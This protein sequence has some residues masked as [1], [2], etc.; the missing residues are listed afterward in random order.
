MFIPISSPGFFHFMSTYYDGTID[1]Q[2]QIQIMPIVFYPLMYKPD[3][4]FSLMEN[5][6]NMFRVTNEGF[7]VH[8]DVMTNFTLA[9]FASETF[10]KLTIRASWEQLSAIT[11]VIL[12]LPQKPLTDHHQQ[13]QM[14][15]FEK[16]LY[17]GNF[18]E[19]HSVELETI[20]LQTDANATQLREFHLS[21]Q[22]SYLFH[23][24]V[25]NGSRQVELEVNLT[26]IPKEDKQLTAPIILL[27]EAMQANSTTYCTIV[28]EMAKDEKIVPTAT[29]IFM[30]HSVIGK[31]EVVNGSQSISVEP[32]ELQAVQNLK[33]YEF[34]I[35][36]GISN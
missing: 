17:V 28:L 14:F 13:Q 36:G 9:A 10:I 33:D 2:G 1:D 7:Q 8:I 20:S 3:I 30:A 27:L 25:V 15:Q 6:Q 12:K 4:E 29:S 24:S 16:P 21:G 35:D 18:T 31:L 22:W 19:A 32:I 34:S 23:L 5:P 11:Y 26:E